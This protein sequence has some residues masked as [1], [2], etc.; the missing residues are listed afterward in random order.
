MAAMD[1]WGGASDAAGEDEQ[2]WEQPESG[3]DA[4]VVLVDARPAMF[5]PCPRGAQD[6]DTSGPATWF[7]AVVGLLVRLT[8]SKV[9]A[10]DNS[11]LSVVFFGSVRLAVVLDRRGRQR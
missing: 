11:L 2:Q 10:N 3:K 5:Q 8:K 9:V 1:V 6:G 4:L 7:Q